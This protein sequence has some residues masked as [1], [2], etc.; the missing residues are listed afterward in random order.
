MDQT[1][2]ENRR[3]ATEMLRSRYIAIKR[4]QRWHT[5][6]SSIESGPSYLFCFDTLRDVL[7]CTRIRLNRCLSRHRRVYSTG[8]KEFSVDLRRNSLL[9]SPREGCFGRS[10]EYNK[11]RS[12]GAELDD[13]SL[14]LYREFIFCRII[15]EV[16]FFQRSIQVILNL[17]VINVSFLVRS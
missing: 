12:G 8:N 9:K 4:V 11:F 5:R 14:N 13:Q 15:H 2:R 3:K 10:Q 17:A 16:I 1:R 7:C 6:P